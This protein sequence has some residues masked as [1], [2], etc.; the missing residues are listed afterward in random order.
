[1]LAHYPIVLKKFIVASWGALVMRGTSALLAPLL[2]MTIS[3][4]EYGIWYLF[5]S[6]MTLVTVCMGFGLRHFLSLA[7]VHT[8]LTEQPML[9]NTVITLYLILAFPCY[10]VLGTCSPL[11][12]VFLFAGKASTLLIIICLLSSFLYLFIDLFLQILRLRAQ[13]YELT[14][15]QGVST[16]TML[17]CAYY[18]TIILRW[19]V[20]GL[21][22]A[23]L[24]GL[25]VIFTI[26]LIPYYNS[27]YISLL[28]RS[29]PTLS[30]VKN[31]I[32]Q[33]IYFMPSALS[34]WLFSSSPRWIL[35][36]YG[37][38]QDVGIYSVADMGTQLF[39]LTI[40]QP[41][42]ASYIPS[43]LDSFR[44]HQHRVASIENYNKKIMY[45]C[46]GTLIIILS[47][48]YIFL[49]PSVNQLL[50]KSYNNAIPYA[51]LLLLGSVFSMGAQFAS[52]Y[53]QYLKHTK[54][55]AI[56]WSLP[57]VISII[58]NLL[59]IPS[60]KIYGC[61][62]SNLISNILSFFVLLSYNYWAFKR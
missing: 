59:L 21:A 55:L 61:A 53:V 16:V 6:L 17:S 39:E 50:P 37:S 54:V 25:L 57:A 51:W 31:F 40:M 44:Q 38:L 18:A 47:I 41:L 10:I 19:S 62:L 24:A 14:I 32:K 45:S 34:P 28:V 7:Y 48:G 43:I 9:I 4:E 13:A 33:T 26:A 49:G 29:R 42:Q 15:I 46:M 1:M 11:I 35:V 5:N 3:P 8:P 27:N 60:L 12:N 22:L 20:M 36:H 58:L 52:I 30:M 23:N 56:V 2:I